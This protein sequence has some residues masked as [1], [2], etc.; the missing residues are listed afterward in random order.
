MHRFILASLY[1]AKPMA[2]FF[3]GNVSGLPDK[4]ATGIALRFPPCLY[5]S[6]AVLS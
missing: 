1:F 3:S 5:R 6:D 4:D 2:H